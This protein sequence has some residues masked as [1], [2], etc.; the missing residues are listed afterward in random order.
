M[1]TPQ[2]APRYA[3]GVWPVS[4]MLLILALVFFIIDALLAGGV[5]SA[6]GLGW[7]LPAGLAT[8]VLSFLVP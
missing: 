4:R 7:L 3:V 1:T 6:S 8:L 5:I 2:P